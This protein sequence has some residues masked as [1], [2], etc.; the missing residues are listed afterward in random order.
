MGLDP[1]R[2]AIIVISIYSFFLAVHFRQWT[3]LP[4]P[5]SRT[6]FTP[7]VIPTSFSFLIFGS[8]F[9]AR[10]FFYFDFLVVTL[11]IPIPPPPSDL[12]RSLLRGLLQVFPI[13]ISPGVANGPP[14]FRFGSFKF[15]KIMRIRSCRTCCLNLILLAVF[16]LSAL[17]MM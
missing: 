14:P 11:S 9:F 6:S 15:L 12:E 16:F 1:L 10:A 4:L 17:L 3:S 2:V 13:D 7:P 8:F 5:L